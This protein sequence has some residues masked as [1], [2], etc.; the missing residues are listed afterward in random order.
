[1][2]TNGSETGRLKIPAGHGY[3]SGGKNKA[4][5]EDCKEPDNIPY[6]GR[7]SKNK[8]THKC[9]GFMKLADKWHN[10]SDSLRSVEKVGGADAINMKSV[11]LCN[12]GGL[13]MPVTSGQGYEKRIN[14]T[15]FNK[16]FQK[17]ILWS[18]GKGFI[19]YVLG[20]D[21]INLNTGNY[22]YEKE[23]LVI[24][25]NTRL[26]FRLMYNS[27][28]TDRKGCVGEGWSHNYGTHIRREKEGGLFYLCLDDGRN[29]PYRRNV[30]D[31]YTPIF[32][33]RGMLKKEKDGFLY[34]TSDGMEYVFDKDGRLLTRKDREGNTDSFFHN[35]EGQL[36]RVSG[37]NGGELFYTYNKEGNLIRVND[38]TGR[39]IRLWYR[40]GRLWKFVNESGHAYVYGYNEN[41][42]LESI[43]TPRGIRGVFN[44]YDAANRVVKQ[45][46]PDGSVAEMMY[47]DENMRSY[48]KNPDGSMVIHEMDE[49]FRN[50]KNI[51]EDGEEVFGY[52]D[53]NQRTFYVDKNGN[54]T[55]Y[56]YDGRGNLTGITNALGQVTEYRYDSNN[57]LQVV[58]AGGKELRRN[59]Y[60]GKGRLIKS[61]DAI[62]RSRETA[63][64]EDG[65]P[66][67]IFQPDKSSIFFEYD[68]RG[69]MISVTDSRGSTYQYTYDSLNRVKAFTDA[70]ENTIQYMY[71]EENHLTS[72]INPEGNAR[73]YTYNESGK[74]V[75]ICDF[76]G[77]E[78]SIEYDAMNNPSK[79]VDKEGRITWRQYDMMGNLKEEILPSGVVISRFY[80]VYNRP[81]KVEIRKN[82]KETE[83]SAVNMYDYDLVGN[84]KHISM[85]N[86]EEVLSELS[87]TY[88]ALNRIVQTINPT[89]GKTL[90]AYN[91]EGY[92]KSITDPAGNV[93]TFSYNDAGEME[94]ATDIYGNTTKY[95]YNLLGQI[96][97]I[98][99]G[100][101]RTIC[102]QYQPG[103][104]KERVIYPNG[105]KT[106]Y[107][108]DS[109]GRVKGKMDG[110]GYGL[111]YHYDSMGRI[112]KVTS[113][114]G[115]EK[116]YAYDLAGNVVSVCNANKMV[117]HYEYSAGGNLT[118][119]TDALGNRTEYTYDIMNNLTGICQRGQY[120]EENREI[121]YERNPLGQTECIRD[122]FGQE[123]YFQ[124]D[125]LGRMV[126]KVDK[127]GYR[128][129][130]AYAPDGKIENIAYGDGTR[131]EME[132]TSLRQI[133]LVRDW[134]GET[135]I[136]RDLQ[137]N[138]VQIMDHEGR[139]V[140]YEWG[141]MGEKRSITY[142]DGKT[143]RYGYDRLLR[144]NELV[145]EETG[146]ENFRIAYQYNRDGKLSE[147]QISEHVSTCWEYNSL[148]LLRELV[149]KDE[150]GI[151]DRYCY[152]YDAM[153]NKVQV[154]KMRRGLSAES[155][156]Y[157]YHYDAIN[158]LKRVEKDGKALRNYSYDSFG[159]RTEMV[160]Y[161][162]DKKTVCIYNALNQM[163]SEE[164][165]E[166]KSIYA[167][168]N[169]SEHLS[170]EGVKKTYTYDLRGN[171]TAEYQGN[172][173]LFGYTYN[174]MNRLGHAWNWKEQD[175]EYY[176]NGIGY[177]VGKSNN[178][179]EEKYLLDLTRPYH[180]L[181]T[182]E[183]G[184]KSQSF[185]WDINTAAMEEDGKSP[186]FYLNDE[187]GS[188]L[189][190]IYRTGKGDV[191][192]YDEFGND[193][194][195][196][197]EATDSSVHYTK[198]GEGQ[199]FG[200]TGY[201]Y[202]D[203][204]GTYFAQMRE[205]R[206]EKGRFTAED[207]IR[208]NGIEPNT[209][210]RYGYCWGNPE[211]MV[212]SDGKFPVALVALIGVATFLCGCGSQNAQEPKGQII[213]P[214]P[215]EPEPIQDK[216]VNLNE[217]SETEP[218]ISEP[219]DISEGQLINNLA[220][221]NIAERTELI[222]L[223]KS[224]ETF[225][226]KAYYA[227]KNEEFK[228]IG[229]GHYCDDPNGD[230][231]KYLV[232]GY[233]MTLEEAEELLV[234]D[235]HEKMP[236]EMLNTLF[237]AD[238][239]SLYDYQVDAL[240]LLSYNLKNF[241]TTSSEG[242]YEYLKGGI[243]SEEKTLNEM[244]TY[245]TQAGNVLG[246]LVKGR[247][248]EAMIFSGLGYP[249]IGEDGFYDDKE[250]GKMLY[251]YAKQF[252]LDDNV[253]DRICKCLD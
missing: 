49:K 173:I 48:V 50:V 77:K 163:V 40:Y 175:A 92:V 140:K 21:P 139:C 200:Y 127:D 177:R 104:L 186:R 203:I 217:P 228:T 141:S 192:G 23:G 155:G 231:A 108:Y 24:S 111:F 113:S 85:G 167:G 129:E 144:L 84:L 142:P 249:E 172:E 10:I 148:G 29:V 161:V 14:L 110:N 64:R 118:A 207:V 86:G 35:N 171:M 7:C 66:K 176:Y 44:E 236:E 240:L 164:V 3:T 56:R 251:N 78:F 132:Y 208:G 245:T 235:L 248:V 18:L 166:K 213:E 114:T 137:G 133:A 47:D 11:L 193:L 6:F 130:Y 212:D 239:I 151:L 20:R 234:Q 82:R 187:L 215:K 31:I 25:G 126:L 185:Y 15:E 197:D 178:G 209:L 45:V 80:D 125:A 52:N 19:C 87:Y 106:D 63:Y 26:S 79:L 5:C 169:I 183:G 219:T 93:K 128:T 134:L 196:L 181:L 112:I 145:Q 222:E 237:Q 221:Y 123:E 154:E 36:I 190:V 90:F 89:G 189:R 252:K 2:C 182:V 16:K 109:L 97:S 98:T 67:Q 233:V 71:D 205:Y 211:N 60:D 243:Y 88:D 168:E 13:I 81:I 33:D 223:L 159:N 194:C 238:G 105:R 138:P 147:K 102:Y 96:A 210:N 150:K 42:R 30:G 253:K 74:I 230:D 179:M 241:T 103:G 70:E 22:I 162:T 54:K 55:K 191:Y 34:R 198:Q 225:Q 226:P 72:I 117:T 214:L 1:M 227:T 12:K 59:T 115:Q 69:N 37:A 188:P 75:N 146:K 122:V 232:E 43:V 9:E 242:F 101:G 120:G 53:S 68:D 94:E 39:E 107:T 195:F 244:L 46:L 204:S 156:S 170:A 157:V 158:R 8:V 229:I 95:T 149:H 124:Y 73:I 51:Y 41:G 62:G 160:D 250:L 76:D 4:N 27:M 58:S 17:T 38:H 220:D 174:A 136:K 206:P 202:D 61:T 201:C 152:D 32:G 83:A 246:G 143:V 224:M 131:V 135:K 65:L 121:F 28:S 100:A 216:V 116:S 184:E 119:V 99:D 165:L 91:M 180:N 218:I 153:G 199:P 57:R 247:I